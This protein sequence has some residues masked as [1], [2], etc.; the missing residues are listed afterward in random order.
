MHELRILLDG[1]SAEFNSRPRP[2]E[3]C[4]AYWLLWGRLGLED[5]N[6]PVF[7]RERRRHPEGIDAIKERGRR[8]GLSPNYLTF[9]PE[10]VREDIVKR[11]A[12]YKVDVHTETDP[13]YDYLESE[14]DF[15]VEVTNPNAGG[16]SLELEFA[17]EFTIFF[18]GTHVHCE[19][20]VAE[21]EGYFLK[22]VM[23]ILEG[24]VSSVSAWVGDQWLASAFTGRMLSPDV[25][26][27]KC[28]A[29]FKH[30]PAEF[31]QR[32]KSPDS[33]IK[34]VNW[35]PHKSFQVRPPQN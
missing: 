5:E 24:K 25:G 30:L 10:D 21:Y 4:L 26:W 1:I 19:T 11:L 14:F 32:L 18:G 6:D 29:L 20:N 33:L 23:Q 22:K 35:L 28:L 2:S 17:D 12:G 15:V 3:G 8:D 9:G 7:V 27:E 34:V 13:E 16:E 31:V